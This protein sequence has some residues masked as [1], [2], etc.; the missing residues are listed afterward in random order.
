MEWSDTG[1]VLK[2]GPF[3][4]SDLWVRLLTQRHGI[5]SVFAFGGSRSKRRF[6]GCLGLLNEIKIRVQT[7]K[8][9]R[10]LSLQEAQLI[11]ALTYVKIDRNKLGILVNCVRFL[12]AIGV[13]T[14][15]AVLNYNLIRELFYYLENSKEYI[16]IIPILFRLRIISD[17]GYA[18]KFFV[19]VKCGVFVEDGFFKLSEG[20]LI[21]KGC[22]EDVRRLFYISKET[23]VL[24]QCVQNNSPSDWIFSE[25]IKL[26]LQQRHECSEIINAFVQYHLGIVW[27]NGRFYRK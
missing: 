15:S 12:E 20:S 23:L 13:N 2:L 16:D 18:P 1:I 19:C 21:C 11:K 10:F 7:S 14:D 4:E 3:R 5:I 9:G 17:Q 22:V 25:D 24:L 6:C 27:D 26:S 8:N